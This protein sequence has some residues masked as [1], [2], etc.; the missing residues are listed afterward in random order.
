M[1]W[2]IFRKSSQDSPLSTQ[3]DE[4]SES[5]MR[6]GAGVLDQLK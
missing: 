2:G 3:R 4:G 5:A 6:Q 1:G